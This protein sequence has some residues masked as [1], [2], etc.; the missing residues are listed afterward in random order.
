M[1]FFNVFPKLSEKQV[2]LS[3]LNV[4]YRIFVNW[5]EKGVIDY[6]VS[7]SATNKDVTRRRV[8]LDYFES[9][10]V[11]IIKELRSFG[12]PLA[13][14]RLIKDFLLAPIDTS[15]FDKL[16][17]K[18]ISV[19][20]GQGLPDEIN[21]LINEQIFNKEKAKSVLDTLPE[22]YRMYATNLGGIVSSVLLAGHTPSLVLYKNPNEDDQSLK[23]QV[24]NPVAHE[25]EANQTGTD[26]R[27]EL[28]NNMIH[29]SIFSIPIMPLISQFY[30]DDG[31]FKY[32]EGFALYSSSELEVL[33]ILKQKDFKQIK[34]YTSHN[35]ESF[36]VEITKEHDIK[37]N[38]AQ[39]IKTLLGL[40]QYERAEI[41]FRNNKHLVIKN[42]L[43]QQI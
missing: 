10:W 11:L 36:E 13:K 39:T 20:L 21:Q 7:E 35:K 28:V 30:K 31:L 2:T 27:D 8:E 18:E 14:I 43:K 17:E 29:L 1:D 33:K 4:P 12:M 22:S 19:I 6:K 41:I 23:F 24:F 40:K 26:F 15:Y 32:T 34:I 42:I 38:E 16:S 3:D 37:N 25:I 9:L 5:S